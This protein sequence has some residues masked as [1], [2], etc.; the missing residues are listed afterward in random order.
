M[1]TVAPRPSSILERVDN[2]VAQQ[3]V[4]KFLAI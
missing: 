4:E 1:E 2:P 3:W